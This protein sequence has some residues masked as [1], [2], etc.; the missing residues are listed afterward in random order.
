MYDII[1]HGRTV[2]EHDIRLRKTFERIQEKGLPLNKD[3]CTFSMSKL[4]FMG[5]LLS[6]QGIRPTESR[7]EAVVDA[8]EPQNA[9]EVRSFLGLVNFS[10]RFILNLASIAEPLHRLTRKQIPFVWGTEQQGAF[11][12]LKDSL[13][14]AEIV[15]F[16]FFFNIFI[17]HFHYFFL[18]LSLLPLYFVTIP[19]K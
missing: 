10:A 2:K 19:V 1:I 16:F 15:P 12:A 9:K 7:V 6:N 4:T 13:A 5:K 17:Y 18:L 11:D 8:R 3:K 14:N